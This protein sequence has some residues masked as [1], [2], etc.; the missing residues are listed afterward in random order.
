MAISE[1]ANAI[2]SVWNWANDLRTAF[3][4]RNGF[5]Y[6]CDF[7]ARL[8]LDIIDA[9]D[10]A[11]LDNQ[12]ASPA[13]ACLT[14]SFETSAT[15]ALEE[16]PEPE[17]IEGM[18]ENFSFAV[19]KIEA[20]RRIAHVAGKEAS[21]LKNFYLDRRLANIKTALLCIRNCLKKVI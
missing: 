9:L 5:L 3:V 10:F 15:L 7:E 4:N 1:I 19:R 14:D 11:K 21:F 17:T 6:A 18:M 8:N 16:T 2:P 20:L 12:A 13:F